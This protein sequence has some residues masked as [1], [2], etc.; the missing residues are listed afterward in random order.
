MVKN[1]PILDYL[2]YLIYL[3]WLRPPPLSI[4]FI[5]FCYLI[6]PTYFLDLLSNIAYYNIVQLLLCICYILYNIYIYYICNNYVNQIGTEPFQVSLTRFSHQVF[7]FYR[8]GNGSR[9]LTDLS[10][11]LCRILK[12]FKSLRMKRILTPLK[13]LLLNKGYIYIYIYLYMYIF[14]YV[15]IYIFVI[16]KKKYY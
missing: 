8:C 15:Y 6:S 5:Y 1:K 11:K 13:Y 14:I 10:F 16:K 7:P 3:F 9:L 4:L 12:K 2:V